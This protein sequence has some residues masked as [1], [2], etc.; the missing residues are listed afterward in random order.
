[1]DKAQLVKN[2]KKAYSSVHG[3]KCKDLELQDWSNE[4]LEKGIKTLGFIAG[5]K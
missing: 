4:E 5:K 3:T 2:Y 1:M